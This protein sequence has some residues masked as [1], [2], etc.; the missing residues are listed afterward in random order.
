MRILTSESWF[1]TK[2]S[3]PSK[4]RS[5]LRVGI[6]RVLNIWSTHQLWT[7]FF[8]ALGVTPDH[9]VFSSDTSEEQGRSFGRGTVDCCYPVKCMSGHYGELIFGQKKK[10]DI[11]FSPLIRSM[12]SIL[13]EYAVDTLACPR[14]MAGPENIKAGFIKEKD[15]FAEQGIKYVSPLVCLAEPRLM[16]KQM[17]EGLKGA[18][19]DLTYAESVKAVEAGYAALGR[20]STMARD[21]SR[22]ILDACAATGTPCILVLARPY[23]MDS[24]I[25]HEIEVDLQAHGY[26]ILWAQYLPIDD[27]IMN[28]MFGADVASGAIRS[29]FDIR[30]VWPSSY[31]SNTNEILWGAKVGAALPQVTCVIRLTSYECGMDQPTY[32]P[33]QQIIE[34]SGTLFFSF[35]DLDSTKPAGSVKLRIE[36]IAHY[37]ARHSPRIMAE[38]LQQ[39]AT[40]F[41]LKPAIAAQ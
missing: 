10:I 3:A 37:L 26:P 2:V 7:G 11:L 14:V 15:V 35:Q 6:P 34:S 38:K 22:D 18:M 9:I 25:G 5:E 24:G 32:S 33:V 20:F 19:P 21:K 1:G 29:P 30:D 41:P 17:H 40:P 36:T 12:P 8:T 4:S 28:W 39:H 31:S 23:H 27:E 16:P 13:S